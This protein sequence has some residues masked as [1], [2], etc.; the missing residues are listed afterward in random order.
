MGACR[1]ARGGRADTH[2]RDEQPS[3]M[4][5]AGQKE[6]SMASI[7]K[8]VKINAPL[9]RVF[10]VVTNPDNWTR[11]VTSLVA[12]THL[13]PEAPAKGSTFRWEYKVMGVRMKG[14]GE[15]TDNVANKRFGLTLKGKATIVED[16]TFTRGDDGIVTLGI[17]IEHN[18]SSELL[19][20]VMDNAL[21][22]KLNSIESGHVLKKIKA[23][24]EA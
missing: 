18:L 17:D 20:M 22:R 10:K 14:R 19:N 1:I 21:M 5:R 24:C 12:V 2:P 23:M 9:S 15:V 3:A 8:T 6:A 13:S 4:A 7:R 16:Y 11:Y